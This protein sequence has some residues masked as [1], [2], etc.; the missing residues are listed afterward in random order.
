MVPLDPI[1]AH[2]LDYTGFGPTGTGF[3]PTHRQRQQAAAARART[4]RAA[5]AM[6]FIDPYVGAFAR[7]ANQV[8]QAAGN[9]GD[10]RQ[11]IYGTASGQAVLDKAMALRRTGMLGHGD[12]LTYSTNIM[13]GVA[14]GGFGIQMG[15]HALQRDENGV[16]R[17]V[18][19]FDPGTRVSGMGAQTEHMGIRVMQQAMDQLYGK[20]EVADPRKTHGFD[21]AEMSMLYNDHLRNNGMGKAMK[22]VSNARAGD[23]LSA[24]LQ[25]EID[26]NV[27]RHLE[28]VASDVDDPN[29]RFAKR[30]QAIFETADD[31]TKAAY[32][33]DP[34]LLDSAALADIS[35][36]FKDPK[37]QKHFKDMADAK[38]AVVTNHQVIKEATDTVKE[39]AGGMASLMDLFGEMS[40]V[41]GIMQRNAMFG[42][43]LRDAR[44]A[45]REN[46]I[47]N[48][49]SAAATLNGIDPQAFGQ[50]AMLRQQDMLQNFKQL[51]GV[52]AKDDSVLNQTVA[53]MSRN[54]DI[55]ANMRLHGAT[56]AA[57][58]A[59]DAGLGNS[60]GE[61]ATL[62]E[63]HA[64]L[65]EGAG[66]LATNYQFVTALAGSKDLFGKEDNAIANR[67]VSEFQNSKDVN[68]RN[69]IEARARAFYMRRGDHKTLETAMKAVREDTGRLG[70]E[71]PYLLGDMIDTVQRGRHQALNRSRLDSVLGGDTAA[72]SVFAEQLGSAGLT[73][74]VDIANTDEAAPGDR[75]KALSELFAKS[76]MSDEQISLTKARYLN[77]DGSLKGGTADELV[78]LSKALTTYEKH[79]TDSV[80][81]KKIEGARS[82]QALGES[83]ARAKLGDQGISI[84]GVLNAFAEGKIT[85]INT[86]EEKIMALKAMHDM[87][88]TIPGAERFDADV[89]LSKLD[90]RTLGRLRSVFGDDFD[91]AGQFGMSEEEF[92][93]KYNEDEGFRAKAFARMQH[94]P[95]ASISGPIDRA[96]LIS[97][98]ALDALEDVDLDK[99]V[100]GGHL[101]AKLLGVDGKDAHAMG[102]NIHIRN[103]LKGNEDGTALAD[104]LKKDFMID[105]GFS[106]RVGLEASDAVKGLVPGWGAWQAFSKATGIGQDTIRSKHKNMERFMSMTDRLLEDPLLAAGLSDEDSLSLEKE[107]RR[108]AKEVETSGKKTVSW[109]EQGKEKTSS[110]E[111]YAAMMKKA[112]DQLLEA[113]TGE[114]K[115]TMEN[116]TVTTLN[117]T[118]MN[119]PS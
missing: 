102:N 119:P 38:T 67:F 116:L 92:M 53:E 70:R 58:A 10:A 86:D 83:S 87:G 17:P 89:D 82:L 41:E 104:A 65:Q 34:A 75:A 112:A 5:V 90:K 15:G 42:T 94:N 93:A 3:A 57:K 100:K 51:Y 48:S 12:P 11:Q 101:A 78:L 81:G 107:Y 50:F 95:D 25:S 49:M 33:A 97:K 72:T 2:Q 68:E 63:I 85:G 32:H 69:A 9:P 44:A 77:N 23:K 18:P 118:N 66:L 20:G 7:T 13:Q 19:V 14:A 74:M 31:D 21:M 45:K 24:A 39:M 36:E 113:R 80:Y 28:D 114:K 117:V 109:T 59:R 60:L 37:I 56:Q 91:L 54:I 71:D 98:E 111:E 110:V 62:D 35:K 30:R 108:I 29:G 52:D 55:Q 22:V 27:R 79:G 6:Q 1:F 40:M 8:F 16:R 47:I 103:A 105:G 46:Q 88:I 73:A 96:A 84:R 76:G 43:R 64:D 61:V 4:Q 115:H 106:A 99:R 26:L